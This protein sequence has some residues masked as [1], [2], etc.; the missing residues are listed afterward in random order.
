MT[1]AREWL[2]IALGYALSC[3]AVVSLAETGDAPSA[4]DKSM[5]AMAPQAMANESGAWA[6]EKSPAEHA[7]YSKFARIHENISE[8]RASL[9]HGIEALKT[10]KVAIITPG[11]PGLMLQSRSSQR[12]WY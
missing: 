10:M 6:K 11:I 3:I 7:K 2:V 4:A 1:N 12:S 8:D 9:P 5:T